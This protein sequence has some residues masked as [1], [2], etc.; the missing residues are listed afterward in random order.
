MANRKRD[1]K[2]EDPR[3]Q[4]IRELRAELRIAQ[5]SVDIAK[6]GEEKASS[7]ADDNKLELKK[8]V[9]ALQDAETKYA[10]TKDILSKEAQEKQ[11]LQDREN[12]FRKEADKLRNQI[13][14]LEIEANLTGNSNMLLDSEMADNNALEQAQNQ[15]TELKQQLSMLQ[16]MTE[17]GDHAVALQQSAAEISKLRS[18]V[19]RLTEHAAEAENLGLSLQEKNRLE[20]EIKTLK[21]Q[22]QNGEQTAARLT[23]TE[24]RLNVAVAEVTQLRSNLLESQTNGQRIA[25]LEAEL[26]STEMARA[27]ARELQQQL[28][29]LDADKAALAQQ[30]AELSGAAAMTGKLQT[31]L[32]ESELEKQELRKDIHKLQIIAKAAEKL[33]AELDRL[34]NMGVELKKSREEVARLSE[35]RQ[36][37]K[38]AH[39]EL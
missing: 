33:K 4:A 10:M 3:D 35:K 29:S 32:N 20:Q 22:S 9:A 19:E 12:Q 28:E 11:E 13:H 18:K 8:A 30:V 34:R 1:P 25:E 23:D 24:T 5:K 14:E 17:T 39:S 27:G 15:I 38:A 26:A 6:A 2:A 16:S 31:Q 7:A 37:E 21:R 36:T